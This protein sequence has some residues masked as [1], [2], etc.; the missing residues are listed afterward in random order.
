MRC[1]KKNA[2]AAQKQL[3]TLCK[4]TDTDTKK[5]TPSKTTPS[6]KCVR[7]HAFAFEASPWC[8][9]V[10]ERRNDMHP[11]E[12]RTP[13]AFQASEWSAQDLIPAL[14]KIHGRH[15]ENKQRISC[16]RIVARKQ[17]HLFLVILGNKAAIPRIPF[18]FLVDKQNL[19]KSLLLHYSQHAPMP[20]RATLSWHGK[21]SKHSFQCSKRRLE[22][23]QSIDMLGL[24]QMTTLIIMWTIPIF[25]TGS[26][27]RIS[28]K[29]R[30]RRRRFL[31][32][33]CQD[34]STSARLV[35]LQHC[36]CMHPWFWKCIICPIKPRRI[37]YSWNVILK[38]CINNMMWFTLSLCEHVIQ[39]TIIRATTTTIP[40]LLAT[41]WCILGR[42]SFQMHHSP[43]IGM[44]P[45]HKL[46]TWW[47]IEAGNRQYVATITTTHHYSCWNA[48]PMLLK[49]AL[50]LWIV[51]ILFYR[52]VHLPCWM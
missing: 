29:W 3:L 39:I 10:S 20:R 30:I 38:D 32:I 50:L 11:A 18:P 42:R 52:N 19:F 45:C 27:L 49:T 41:M 14:V 33:T 15:W 37:R 31:T 48:C 26:C 17:Q 40:A 34:A 9:D 4:H 13:Y 2:N 12:I 23:F 16:S 51:K 7:V 6:T 36:L 28:L 24:H 22:C 21:H 5:N 35:E 43:Y 1:K 25:P 44:M 47:R 46:R 8:H